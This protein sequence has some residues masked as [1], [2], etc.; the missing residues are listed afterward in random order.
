MSTKKASQG[1]ANKPNQGVDDT[2]KVV[3]KALRE[4]RMQVADNARMMKMPWPQPEMVMDDKSL[5]V[6]VQMVA[7]RGDPDLIRNRLSFWSLEAIY[8]DHLLGHI[9]KIRLPQVPGKAP[10]AKPPPPKPPADEEP[11]DPRYVR[12]EG[13]PKG[14][15]PYSFKSGPS[16]TPVELDRGMMLTHLPLTGYIDNYLGKDLF[17]GTNDKGGKE[18][19]QADERKEEPSV[20]D[21]AEAVQLLQ[22]MMQAHARARTTG[23]INRNR[24]QSDNGWGRYSD[25]EDEDSDWGDLSDCSATSS[26]Q[27]AAKQHVKQTLRDFASRFEREFGIG[28]HNSDEDSWTDDDGDD[29]DERISID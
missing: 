21:T 12:Y 23:A 4:W 29:D 11:W 24:V 5:D 15:K 14:D 22:A 1:K 27:R 7:E 3:R 8:G 18:S 10:A 2:E 17:N 19:K 20:A 13:L 25:E 26:V 9:K 6:V 16:K 28:G